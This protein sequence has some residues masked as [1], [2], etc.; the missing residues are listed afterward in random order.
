MMVDFGMFVIDADTQ[1]RFLLRCCYQF[2]IFI[3]I[4]LFA[5][6]IAACVV[7]CW[8]AGKRNVC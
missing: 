8:I 2:E 1:V 7:S 3:R 6:I 4:A 5:L